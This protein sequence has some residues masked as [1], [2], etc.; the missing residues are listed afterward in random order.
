MV[1]VRNSLLNGVGFA[2]VRSFSMVGERRSARDPPLLSAREIFS[3]D[4]WL[5]VLGWEIDTVAMTTT[6]PT[7]KFAKLRDSLRVSGR[8]TGYS[9]LR[10]KRDRS[11]GILL[12][13]REVTSGRKDF[14]TPQAQS[15]RLAPVKTWREHG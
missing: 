13:V 9:V 4:T 12:H 1:S 10:R 6:P 14:R 7:A 11:L 8:W 15:I 5:E 3:W 2:S